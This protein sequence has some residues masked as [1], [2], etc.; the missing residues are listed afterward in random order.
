LDPSLKVD[1]TSLLYFEEEEE[2]VKL[3]MG[4]Y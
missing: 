3:A 4:P 2:D 1:A